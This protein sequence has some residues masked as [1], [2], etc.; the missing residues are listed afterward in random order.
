MKRTR[1]AAWLRTLP[2]W[3]GADVLSRGLRLLKASGLSHW[4]VVNPRL[5][6]LSRSAALT[7]QPVSNPMTKTLERPE[8][9]VGELYYK[10]LP[11]RKR[12][13]R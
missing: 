3:P 12:F 4:Q 1:L 5:L 9:A 8:K 6:R 10:T 7:S 11:P 13:K 2:L